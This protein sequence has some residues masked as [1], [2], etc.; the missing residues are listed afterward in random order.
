MR[1]QHIGKYVS[2]SKN[3]SS[4]IKS[5][6]S[7]DYPKYIMNSNSKIMLNG[8]VFIIGWI[9]DMRFNGDNSFLFSMFQK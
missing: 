9:M 1:H 6:Y 8:K 7:I 2:N 5:R 3:K 4:K